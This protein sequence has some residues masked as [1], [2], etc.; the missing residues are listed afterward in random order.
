[1]LI[2]IL[3]PLSRD[4]CLSAVIYKMS[5]DISLEDDSDLV[6][7]DYDSAVGSVSN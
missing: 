3:S 2:D 5:D 6:L 7:Q 1:M 4:G